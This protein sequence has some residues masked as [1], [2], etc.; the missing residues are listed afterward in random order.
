MYNF[1][2]NMIVWE[3]KMPQLVLSK[4]IFTSVIGGA[5]T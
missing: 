5:R 3:N 2:E 1:S 4:V